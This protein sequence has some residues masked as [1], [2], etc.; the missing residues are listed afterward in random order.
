MLRGQL[1]H[2][3]LPVSFPVQLLPLTFGDTLLCPPRLP[4]ALDV[5]HATPGVPT[6]PSA[7]VRRKIF[8]RLSPVARR[9]RRESARGVVTPS[10]P[11]FCLA[12][13]FLVEPCPGLRS[14]PLPRPPP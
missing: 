14:N 12:V 4:L 10:G 5:T 3:P 11:R 9:A 1:A 8:Q 7:L 2:A 6:V 13:R